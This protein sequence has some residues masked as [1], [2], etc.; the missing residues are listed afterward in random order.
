VTTGSATG[1]RTILAADVALHVRLTVGFGGSRDTYPNSPMGAVALA[2]QALLD[3]QW[4]E[5]AWNAYRASPTLPRPERND[6]LAALAPYLRSQKRVIF[7]AA[8]EQF[9]D[10]ADRFAKEFVL[11]AIIRGSGR[12]YRRLTEIKESGRPVLVPV[13]FPAAPR[14]TSIEESRDVSLEQLMHWDHAPENAGRLDKAGVT[15][16]LTSYGLRDPAKFLENVRRAVERGLSADAALK[17]LTVTPAAL[18]GVENKLGS[19]APGKVASLVVTDGDLFAKKTKVVETWVDGERFGSMR[20]CGSIPRDLEAGAGRRPGTVPQ[21]DA[22]APRH[23]QAAFRHDRAGRGARRRHEGGDQAQPRAAA[24][25]APVAVV[26]RQ[27]VRA[28]GA[29]AA[30]CGRVESGGEA[31]AAGRGAVGRRHSRAGEGGADGAAVGGGKEKTGGEGE[32]A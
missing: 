11:S 29:G 25:G 30:E 17:A 32:E 24:R 26:R 18:Y 7:D 19:I 2:R 22:Q 13:N 16:A 1:T 15:I 12:E 3:A 23:S 28:R 5:E 31:D 6:A 8:N 4:Y 14:V 27:E 9:F 20:H 10:R 21:G